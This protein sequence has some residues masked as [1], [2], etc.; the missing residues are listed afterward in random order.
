MKKIL[1]LLLAVVMLFALAAC[2]GE[3]D[4]TGAEEHQPVGGESFEITPANYTRNQFVDKVLEYVAAHTPNSKFH[5]EDGYIPEEQNGFQ[6]MY[7]VKDF[8][9]EHVLNLFP[10]ATNH[11]VDKQANGWLVIDSFR[12]EFQGYTKYTVSL[13]YTDYFQDL[14][15]VTANAKSDAG[16]VALFYNLE[17]E[18]M[19]FYTN[20]N[21]KRQYV[22]LTEETCAKLVSG[23]YTKVVGV[24][25]FLLPYGDDCIIE[26][27]MAQAETGWYEYS[28]KLRLQF[29]D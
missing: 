2:S 19:K 4:T 24:P 12:Y 23:E 15:L 14:K 25:D 27:S 1:A 28:C 5:Y 7:Y 8:D 3:D 13:Y 11:A 20:I 16:R 22:E 6:E 9:E 21:G 18:E 17:P 10:Y 26:I 29:Q